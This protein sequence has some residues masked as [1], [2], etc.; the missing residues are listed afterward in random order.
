MDSSNKPA[1][2]AI[3]ANL[4]MTQLGGPFVRALMFV[5]SE[6]FKI[7]PDFQFLTTN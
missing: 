2:V 5:R 1:I 6:S 7:R 4:A 3:I